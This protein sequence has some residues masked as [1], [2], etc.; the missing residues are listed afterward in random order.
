MLNYVIKGNICFSKTSKE[1]SVIENG[2]AVCEN[3][4][5]AGVYQALPRAMK[6]FRSMII[7]TKS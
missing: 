6:L 2:Y 1:L 4:R 5:S 7:R 3:G